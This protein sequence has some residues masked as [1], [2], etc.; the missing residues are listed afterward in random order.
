[1]KKLLLL[2]PCCLLAVSPGFAQEPRLD[3]GVVAEVVRT[4]TTERNSAEIL[5]S[6]N[7][8]ANYRELAVLQALAREAAR[9]G[10]AEQMSVQR[11]LEI[12]RRNVLVA[13]LR[14]EVAAQVPD[15]SDSKLKAAFQASTNDWMQ[16]EGFR[17]DLYRLTPQEEEAMAMARSLATGEPVADADLADLPAQQILS[18]T[19]DVWLDASHMTTQVWTGV[20]SMKK[21]ELRLFPDGDNTLVIRRGTYRPPK[22]L[23]FEDVRPLLKVSVRREQEEAAWAAFVKQTS[24]SLGL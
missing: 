11:A 8:L 21:N 16:P 22:R 15:P 9:R 17:L 18:Q 1:M 6:T 12:A 24:E 20:R 14:A 5:S 10:L 13:A 4:M 19:N 2:L 3:H 7:L 23:R